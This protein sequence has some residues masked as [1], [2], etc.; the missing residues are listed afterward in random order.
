MHSTGGWR[1]NERETRGGRREGEVR[2]GGERGESGRRGRREKE[3]GEEG[4]ERET[5]S[6]MEMRLRLNNGNCII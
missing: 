2:G 4:G 1:L 6:V 3:R 5:V